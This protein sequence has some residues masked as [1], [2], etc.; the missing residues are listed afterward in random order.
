[1]SE[2][3]MRVSR[4]ERDHWAQRDGREERYERIARR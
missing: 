3:E 4:E 1:M 2:G